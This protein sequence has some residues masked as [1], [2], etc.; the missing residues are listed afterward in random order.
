MAPPQLP[1]DAPVVNVRHPVHVRLL[2]HGRREL[3]MPLFHGGDGFVG[4]RLNFEE[5]L[6]GQPRLDHGAAAL[7]GG[8]GK[9][10]VLD[11]DQQAKCVEV[12]DDA[13]SRHIPI[14]AVIGRSGQVDMRG[15]VHDG[16]LGQGMPLADLVVVRIVR[17]RD[18]HRA[19]AELRLCPFVRQQRDFA[20]HKWQ[21]NRLT[22]Q[23][24]VA[25]ICRVHHH[26]NVTQHRF[27][28]SGWQ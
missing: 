4:E 12:G 24:G 15:L 14:H 7:R 11:L 20:M 3:D 27:G 9:R 8:D 28:A 19:G 18:L 21:Q 16:Q 23:R 26:R 6:H 25:L 13:F 2:V 10:V 17:G 22:D 5:P 1:R